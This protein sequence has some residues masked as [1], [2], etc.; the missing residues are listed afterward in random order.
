[1][2]AAQAAQGGGGGRLSPGSVPGLSGCRRTR[3]GAGSD[4]GSVLGWVSLVPEADRSLR[5][6]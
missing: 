6:G 4:L 2:A 1:M 5:F 3:L